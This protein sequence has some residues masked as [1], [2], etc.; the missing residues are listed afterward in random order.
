MTSETCRFYRQFF[1]FCFY[2]V[3]S[4]ISFT[5]R[6]GPLI[7]EAENANDTKTNSSNITAAELAILKS[8]QSSELSDLVTNSFSAA[9]TSN[10]KSSLN[11]TQESLEKIQLQV[12][13]NITLALKNIL[14]LTLND[15]EGI[16]SAPDEAAIRTLWYTSNSNNESDYMTDAYNESVISDANLTTETVI[17][18]IELPESND[19]VNWCVVTYTKITVS[20]SWNII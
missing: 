19:E 13:S 1:L 9:F 20:R 18:S 7:Q 4:L 10:L 15:N 11:V 16:L 3:L 17:D 12:T 14:L 2:F 8:F 5:L 6:P